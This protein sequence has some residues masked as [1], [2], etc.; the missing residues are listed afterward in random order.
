[1]NKRIKHLALDAGFELGRDWQ[2]IGQSEDALKTYTKLLLRECVS[3]CWQESRAAGANGD[4]AEYTA[5][6]KVGEQIK[7]HFGVE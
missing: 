3:I 4:L 1:M 6:S 7:K 2:V 5:L